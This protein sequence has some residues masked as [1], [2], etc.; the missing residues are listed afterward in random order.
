MDRETAR[1]LFHMTVGLIAL[2][3][4]L[5]F[6]KGFMTAAVFFTI[7][8]GTILINARMRGLKIPLV[9]WFEERFE[10]ES[11]PVPGWGSACYA[12]GALLAITFLPEAAQIAAAIF[13]LG[14]GDGVSTIIGRRG[15]MRLPYNKDKT[16]EGSLAF[17]VA[18]LPAYAF[19]GPA[20]V[21]L[22]LIAAIAE[23]LP[24]IEDNL[25]IPL[26]CTIF[27]LAVR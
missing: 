18:C 3:G 23:S 15:R 13:I 20:V 7:I 5:A 11:A 10:R 26:V 25:L 2:A 22:A 8:L 19:I 27:L 14:I 1:Q 21:P 9:Q 16:V 6:G 12:A 24:G 4:L 17:F